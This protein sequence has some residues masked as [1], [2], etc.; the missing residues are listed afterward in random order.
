MEVITGVYFFILCG[1]SIVAIFLFLFALVTNNDELKVGS[2]IIIL[3]LFVL[4]WGLIAWVASFETRVEIIPK[5]SLEILVGKNKIIVNDLRSNLSEIFTDIE[6]YKKVIESHDSTFY[7]Q[8]GYN[9][10]NS[11]LK[12]ECKI[13][14]K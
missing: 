6:T 13:N 12:S 7:V 2:G 1:L 8:R 14:S 5:K 9:L 3:A 4:G 10:Y 11:E